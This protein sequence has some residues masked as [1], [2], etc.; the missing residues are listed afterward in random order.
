MSH[1]STIIFR[2]NRRLKEV[3][4]GD[5]QKAAHDS[6]WIESV[7]NLMEY[8]EAWKDQTPQEITQANQ[9]YSKYSKYLKS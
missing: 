1:L 5:E 4:K 9:L 8:Q 7:K 3:Y 6:L 2:V